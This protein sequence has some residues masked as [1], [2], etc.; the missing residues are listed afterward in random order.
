MLTA[1]YCF[2]NLGWPPSQY[3]RLPY[4]EKLLVTQF[5]LKAINDQREAEEKLKRR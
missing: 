5:A 4:G 2:V 3:D 1:Y